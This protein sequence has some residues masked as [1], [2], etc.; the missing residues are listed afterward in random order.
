MVWVAR[1]AVEVGARAVTAAGDFR[2]HFVAHT[3]SE[4]SPHQC[5]MLGMRLRQRGAPR[6]LRGSDPSEQHRL[7]LCVSKS[8]SSRNQK[9]QC[10]NCYHDAQRGGSAGDRD[11]EDRIVGVE[12][13]RRM[14]RSYPAD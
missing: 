2:E 11:L 8:V 9:T 7:K 6:V 3:R 14:I 13:E 1:E 10:S 5:R 12:D 4:K